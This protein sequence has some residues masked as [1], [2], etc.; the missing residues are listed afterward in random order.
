MKNNPSSTFTVS[1]IL[2]F[3]PVL[4]PPEGFILGLFFLSLFFFF[5]PGFPEKSLS[6]VLDLQG[7]PGLRGAFSSFFFFSFSFS[8]FSP[9]PSSFFS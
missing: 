1:F 2:C 7:L 6:S 5:G 3:H 8:N 9:K 4:G